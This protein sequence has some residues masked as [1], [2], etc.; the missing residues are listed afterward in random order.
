LVPAELTA[1]VTSGCASTA[2]LRALFRPAAP[3]RVTVTE[4]LAITE[5]TPIPGIDDVSSGGDGPQP[6]ILR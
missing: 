4:A 3:G 1:L 2:S 6:D 5:R